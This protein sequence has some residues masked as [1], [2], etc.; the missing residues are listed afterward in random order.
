MGSWMW[1]S[2]CGVSKQR[3]P[4]A[5]VP[6]QRGSLSGACMSRLVNS[7]RRIDYVLFG[8]LEDFERFIILQEAFFDVH[9]FKLSNSEWNVEV[10]VNLSISLSP[11]AAGGSRGFRVGFTSQSCINFF[12]QAFKAFAH[13]ICLTYNI[14]IHLYNLYLLNFFS[15]IQRLATNAVP[16]NAILRLK[17][18][19]VAFW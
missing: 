14:Q 18:A 16:T 3:L 13:L 10:G 12:E 7:G 19:L 17:L 8:G 2:F 4:Q 11:K 5:S 15:F 6:R 9:S 1:C